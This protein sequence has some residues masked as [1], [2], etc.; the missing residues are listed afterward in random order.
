M[1]R[2]L[3]AVGFQCIKNQK[4]LNSLFEKIMEEP[5]CFECVPMEHDSDFAMMSREFAPGMGVALYGRL[6]ENQKF[7]SQFYVPYV[8]G[9]IPS[10]EVECFF[11]EHADKESFAGSCDDYRINISLIF[12]VTNIMELRGMVE[13]TGS[14]QKSCSVCFTG[15]SVDGKILL[16]MQKT[17][18]EKEMAK[19]AVKK[20]VDMITSMNGINP[21]LVE[22][23]GRKELE[24]FRDA[25]IKLRTSD[26]YSVIDTYFMPYGVECDHYSVMG[27]IEDVAVVQNLLTKELVYRLMIDC[28]DVPIEIVIQKN[29]LLG[30]PEVGRRFKGSIWLTGTVNF[31]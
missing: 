11:H 7:Q 2:F 17:A 25:G 31:V 20:R 26:L 5:D 24:N 10:T 21:E 27:T 16:P 9:S 19:M 3:N 1:H 29:D 4:Q 8:K 30:I 13:R 12:A 15:L 22:Q 28:N 14:I 23:I 6:D 18:K